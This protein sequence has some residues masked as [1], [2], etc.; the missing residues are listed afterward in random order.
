MAL[1]AFILGTGWGGFDRFYVGT[2]RSTHDEVKIYGFEAEFESRGVCVLMSA[3]RVIVRFVFGPCLR[4][5]VGIGWEL[6]G[7]E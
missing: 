3:M 7:M 2:K 5:L 6:D 1:F 4:S